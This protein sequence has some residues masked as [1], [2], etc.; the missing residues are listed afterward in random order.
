[1]HS[2]GRAKDILYMHDTFEVFSGNLP[3]L[4]ESWRT[5]VS[6]ELH[7]NAKQIIQEVPT[8]FFGDLTDRIR[9][10]ARIDQ[11]RSLTAEEIMEFCQYAWSQVL[12]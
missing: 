5:S 4:A 10:A 6:A 1:M 12:H 3:L 8:S 11:A 7:A 9:Q 2:I